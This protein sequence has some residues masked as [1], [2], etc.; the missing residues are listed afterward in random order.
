M[1]RTMLGTR[2][3]TISVRTGL[4]EDPARAF[5]LTCVCVRWEKLD[6]SFGTPSDTLPP[7]TSISQ[8]IDPRTCPVAE[9]TTK[10]SE[11]LVYIDNCMKCAIYRG[12]IS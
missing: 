7:G 2:V 11:H 3:Q 10:Y 5:N 9:V 8:P 12:C 6:C 4:L 1:P